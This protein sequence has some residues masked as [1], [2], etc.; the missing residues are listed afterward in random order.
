[1]QARRLALL[2]IAVPA[3][4]ATVGPS[5]TAPASIGAP[6]GRWGGP[7]GTRQC[8]WAVAVLALLVLEVGLAAVV[9]ALR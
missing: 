1:M 7:P 4:I 2:L 8:S 5:G 3:W 6:D 9:L